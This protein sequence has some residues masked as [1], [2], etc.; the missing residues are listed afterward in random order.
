VPVIRADGKTGPVTVASGTRVSLKV[1]LD[2]G[3]QIGKNADWWVVAHT[4]F[5]PPNN[6]YS[7]VYPKL[8]DWRPGLHVCVQTPLFQLV[9]P[10]EVL[11]MALPKGDYTFYFAVDDNADGVVDETWVDS[12][13]VRV[14]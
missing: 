5:A 1:T 13:K 4:P 9:R 10:F 6:W 11:N 3:D 8:N 14:E 2:P 12:V 7:Y